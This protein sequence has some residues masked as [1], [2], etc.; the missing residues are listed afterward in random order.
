MADLAVKPDSVTMAD[1]GLSG[2]CGFA[3]KEGIDRFAGKSE[4]AE[5]RSDLRESVIRNDLLGAGAAGC[6]WLV[7]LQGAADAS[8]G[9]MLLVRW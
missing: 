8:G 7:V 4:I 3:A 6:C 2:F 1:S 9:A 5:G